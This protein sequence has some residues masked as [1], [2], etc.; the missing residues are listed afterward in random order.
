[1][2][3]TIDDVKKYVNVSQNL[4]FDDNIKPF[5]QAAKDYL[6]N[7]IS[8]ISKINI[9][10]HPKLK[11]L[12]DGFTAYY[13]VLFALDGIRSK[14]SQQGLTL[15]VGDSSKSVKPS[16]DTDYMNKVNFYNANCFA[17]LSKIYKELRKNATLY[18]IVSL[19]DNDFC[20]YEFFCK[21]SFSDSYSV[22]I[23]L[24]PFF[25]EAINLKIRNVLGDGLFED[26]E[27]YLLAK[28]KNQSLVI[29]PSKY[30][31]LE[32]HINYLML[33]YALQKYVGYNNNLASNESGLFEMIITPAKYVFDK[34]FM[35]K[36]LH[37][38]I[39]AYEQNL[40][41]F[42]NKNQRN[43]PKFTFQSA[44]NTEVIKPTGI[45]GYAFFL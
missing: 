45:D 44:E 34:G 36:D 37:E 23:R 12:V 7:K 9:E 20:N 26:F 1:M 19:E 29:F 16:T 15:L 21:N 27:K 2:I 42:V 13:A 35:L 22:Y 6:E 30:L 10:A 14:P 28:L 18:N 17:Y 33:N 32:T 8:E 40:V 43:L 38:K 3:Q 31:E 25:Q 11:D 24:F 39:V 4:S 5:L 41:N